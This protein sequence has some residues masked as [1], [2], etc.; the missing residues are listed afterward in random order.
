MIVPVL[1]RDQLEQTVPSPQV[2]A[3]LDQWVE[4][5]K[6]VGVYQHA[7]AWHPDAGFHRFVSVR[8]GQKPS[9]P[10]LPPYQLIGVYFG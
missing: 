9:A 4:D 6:G 2:L 5:G 10:L 8:P 3:L 1:S 7:G